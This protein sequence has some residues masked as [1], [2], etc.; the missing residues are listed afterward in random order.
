MTPARKSS[1]LS[2]TALLLLLLVCWLAPSSADKFID[3]NEDNDLI[4]LEKLNRILTQTQN[5]RPEE[6]AAELA[7]TESKAKDRA[8]FGKYTVYELLTVNRYEGA[9]LHYC[10][11]GETEFRLETCDK[12]AKDNN[13]LGNYCRYCTSKYFEVCARSIP[14]ML[15]KNILDSDRVPELQLKQ[16]RR[17]VDQLKAFTRRD[18]FE[19]RDE[20]FNFALLIKKKKDAVT[21]WNRIK[22]TCEQVNEDF[23]RDV[24]YFDEEAEL[25][26]EYLAQHLPEDMPDRAERIQVGYCGVFL[27]VAEYLK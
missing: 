20:S 18:G 17:L 2:L 19:D 1:A 3:V 25:S 8:V 27:D 7:R 12:L 11:K 16:I 13:N 22:G 15:A 21:A 5:M 9:Y 4:S 14:Q 6:V 23:E 10:S 26:A 24:K